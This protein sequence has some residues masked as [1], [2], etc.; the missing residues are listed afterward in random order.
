MQQP[1]TPRVLNIKPRRAPVALLLSV[2][3]P[4]LGQMYNGQFRKGLLFFGLLSALQVVYGFMHDSLSINGVF[5]FM[6]SIL[7]LRALCILDA[8]PH[9]RL[10]KAYTPKFYNTRG[11]YIVVMIIMAL[12]M[13]FTRAEELSGL[14]LFKMPSSPPKTVRTAGCFPAEGDVN[15]YTIS[16]NSLLIH[17]IL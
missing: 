10:Q 6:V 5:G 14:K 8:I 15:C 2:F 7:L 4:G 13:W 9:A 1:F 11:Y 3:F 12:L 16:S 17:V